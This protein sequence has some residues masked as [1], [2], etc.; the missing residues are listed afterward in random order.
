MLII[1]VVSNAWFQWV[2]L[3]LHTKIMLKV[4]TIFRRFQSSNVEMKD[5]QMQ[6]KPNLSIVLQV[7][8]KLGACEKWRVNQAFICASHTTMFTFL[9]GIFFPPK[10]STFMFTDLISLY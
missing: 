1:F 2:M 4:D 7:P 8:S 3:L 6:P 9:V 5:F 10:G